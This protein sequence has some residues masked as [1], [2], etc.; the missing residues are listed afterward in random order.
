M[1]IGDSSRVPW[2]TKTTTVAVADPGVVIQSVEF[3]ARSLQSAT[4]SSTFPIMSNAP[5]F[6]L[7]AERDPVLAWLHGHAELRREVARAARVFP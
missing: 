7:H 4:H 1:G 5:Q 3:T 6:D 2:P